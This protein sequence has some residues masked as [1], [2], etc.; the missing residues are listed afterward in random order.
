[1]EANAITP[2][3][4]LKLLVVSSMVFCNTFMMTSLMPFLT[5]LVDDFHVAPTEDDIG[6][7]SGYLVS[8][9]MLGQLVFSYFWGLLSDR[10]GRRPV[11]LWGLF[12]TGIFFLSFG[13]TT[14]YEAAL[15]IRFAT[16]SFNGIIGMPVKK[17]VSFFLRS[18]QDIS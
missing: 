2:L 12:L 16:G 14:T 9:F 5:F 15:I 13:F 8:S 7:Y 6:R 17:I 11:M 4:W 3:P 18:N 1:M 10:L